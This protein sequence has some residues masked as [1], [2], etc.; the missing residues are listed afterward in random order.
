MRIGTKDLPGEFIQ[1]GSSMKLGALQEL[2]HP[3]TEVRETLLTG[4]GL[5]RS[6]YRAQFLPM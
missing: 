3:G 5:V 4:L 1:G 2:S 6:W